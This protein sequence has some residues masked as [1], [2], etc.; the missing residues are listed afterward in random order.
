MVDPAFLLELCHDVPD[1]ADRDGEPDAHVALSI[2]TAGLDRRVDPDH[3]TLRA[4]QRTARVPVIQRG[5]GLDGVVDR[6]AAP[7][8]KRALDSAH[9]ASGGAAL[10]A[11]G[12]ADRQH[13]VADA[14]RGR[15]TERQRP[16]RPR[17]RLDLEQR[18][19]GGGI[20]A[21]DLRLHRVVVREAD[22]DG[23]GV[24]DDVEVRDDVAGF[25]DDEA[26]AERALGLVGDVEAVERI[27]LDP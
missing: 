4:H 3:L 9:D 7:R 20:L 1:G 24:L 18:D 5:I 22:L 25:V 10:E 19:V 27:G 26:G 13:V 12:I 2:G 11:E 23:V 21:D 17:A 16:Q 8:A 6:E 15:V 14:D